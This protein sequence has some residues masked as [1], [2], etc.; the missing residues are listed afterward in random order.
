MTNDDVHSA[1]VRWIKAKTGVIA[2]KAHQSGRTPALPYVMVND[3]GT[4]EVRRW[5]QQTEYTETDAENSAGEKIV[6]AAPVIEME[7]RFSVHAYGPSPTD[8]LRPIVSAVKVSQAMEPLM[9]GL[10]VH[11]VSAIRDVP[12]WINNAWQPRAQ[13][14]IIVRGIIRDSVGEVDVIDEYSF[15]IARAE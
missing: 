7:W 13:M 2:I 3:T 6:T 12:D 10:H 14:D 1:V 15:E 11:E 8:R 4:A 5:H 9:P